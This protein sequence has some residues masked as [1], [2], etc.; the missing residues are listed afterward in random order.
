MARRKPK[1]KRAQPFQPKKV[2]DG[3]IHIPKVKVRGVMAPPSHFH[4]DQSR[5]TRKTKHKGKF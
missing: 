4:R 1:T 3:K 5:Y 2:D